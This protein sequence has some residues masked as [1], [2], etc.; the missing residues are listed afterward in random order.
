MIQPHLTIDLNADLGEGGMQDE[1][2]MP[3]IS[4]AN[5]ACGG[6]A[7]NPDT[8]RTAIEAARRHGIAIGAHPGYQDPEHFGRRPLSLPVD[9]IRTQIREQLERFLSLCP[10]IHHIKPHGA[11]YHQA[12]QNHELAAMLCALIQQLSPRAILYAPPCGALARAAAATGLQHCPE[13]FIDRRYL[14]DGSLQA[15]VKPGAVI[16]DPGTA[17]A[18]ALQIAC[19][20]QVTPTNGPAIPLPAR[21]LCIHSDS[22]D[23]VSMLARVRQHLEANGIEIRAG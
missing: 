9:E 6:H 1:E 12:N 23:A 8:M 5:I 16:H 21:T 10:D 4:S 20:R 22:P 14:A 13:G 7:G 15:R 11:L 18:Q 2:L 3:L 19:T 17:C